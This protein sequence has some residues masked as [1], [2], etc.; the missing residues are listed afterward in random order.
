MQKLISLLSV[1]PVLAW[2]YNSV[3]KLLRIPIEPTFG[4]T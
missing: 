1:N 3:N 4:K 2:D